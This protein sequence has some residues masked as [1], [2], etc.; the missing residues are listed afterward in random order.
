M[1]LPAASLAAFVLARYAFRGREVVYGLFTLGL[2]FPVAVAILP[3]FIVLRQVGLLSNPLGVAL[4]QAAFASADLDH[5]HAPVLPRDAP[6]AAG[7]GAR[8]TGAVRSASTGR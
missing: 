6:G 8:S 7:R 2:L 3:L 4:P 5:H 1:V